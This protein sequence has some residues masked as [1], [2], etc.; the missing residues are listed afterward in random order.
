MGVTEN[1]GDAKVFW[2]ESTPHISLR[3]HISA[4]ECDIHG[5]DTC[6][7]RLCPSADSAP[8]FFHLTPRKLGEISII[9]KVYQETDWLGNARVQTIV[10]EQ[11]VGRVQTEVT[12]YKIGG[13]MIKVLFLAANPLS[14]GDS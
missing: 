3:V 1:S 14:G 5:S 6:S 4:P 12:S 8:F 10:R 13:E 2:S 9:V 7:V 11:I